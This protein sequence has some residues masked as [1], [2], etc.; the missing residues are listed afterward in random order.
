MVLCM[1]NP[2]TYLKQDWVNFEATKKISTII[3]PKFKEPK[4]KSVIYQ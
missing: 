4:V 1:K 3:M 2:L